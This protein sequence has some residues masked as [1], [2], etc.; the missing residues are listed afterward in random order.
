VGSSAASGDLTSPPSPFDDLPADMD[1]AVAPVWERVADWSTRTPPRRRELG[2]PVRVIAVTIPKGGPGKTSTSVNGSAILAGFGKRVLYIDANAQQADGA[3]LLNAPANAPT[4]ADLAQGGAITKERALAALTR[5]KVPGTM[6]ALY[7]PRN[8]RQ[9]NPLLITP[10]LYC[11]ALDAVV[12]EFDYVIIDG[13]IAE[14]YREIIDGFILTKADFILSPITPDVKT[15]TNAYLWLMNT[16]DERYAGS[17][18]Y[19]A[20]Q[21]GW[22]INRAEDDIAFSI[23][24]A[25][26]S[27]SRPRDDEW[28]YLG[29]IPDLKA[30]RRAGNLAT[31]PDDP[32]YVT[33]ISKIFYEVTRDEDLKQGFEGKL[34]RPSKE[35]RFRKG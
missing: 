4:I 22:F 23:E 28:R 12:D 6:Y 11:E 2:E 33:A 7:G 26:S 13:P 27:L 30:V 31:I 17:D 8:P 29:E 21:I 20:N 32:A 18:A 16:T 19:P 9:A 14:I 25:R 24:D 34:P 3:T 5:V 10:Q 1:N 15:V 35:R